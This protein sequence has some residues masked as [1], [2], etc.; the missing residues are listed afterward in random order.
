MRWHV[1]TSLLLILIIA[2]PIPTG[3]GATKPELPSNSPS[4]IISTALASIPSDGSFHPAFFITLMKNGKP[5][6]T[7]EKVNVTL[8]C[9]DE[10]T[11]SVP[12]SVIISEGGYY[13]IVNASSTIQEKKTV[14]VSASASNYLSSKLTA[15]VQPPTGTPTSLKV[16]LLPDILEPKSGTLSEMIVTLVDTYG[17]PAK[18][19][20]DVEVT[21][22]SSNLHFVDVYPKSI[23]IGE[24]SYSAKANIVSQGYVGS[25]TISASTSDFKP[26]SVVAKVSGA[27]PEKLVIWTPSSLGV[28]EET[29]VFI[30]IVD[31]L[32]K[33]AKTPKSLT[34]SLYSTNTTVVSVSASSKILADDWTGTAQITANTPGKATIYAISDELSSIK[35][36]ITVEKAIGNATSL[37]VYPLT[38]YFPADEKTTNVVAV[39]LVDSAGKPVLNRTTTVGVFSTDST[40]LDVMGSIIVGASSSVTFVTGIPTTMG[41]VKITALSGNLQAGE[42]TVN[43]YSPQTTS[44]SVI[45]PPIPSD[46]VVDAC[47]LSTNSG[48]P[49]PMTQDT[50]ILLT[51]GNTQILGVTGSVIL[52]KKNYYTIIQL[53]GVSPGDT[54]ITVQGNGIPTVSSEIKV[55]EVKPTVFSIFYVPALSYIEFPVVI[56]TVTLSGSPVDCDAPI[57]IRITSSNSTSISVPSFVNVPRD[58][59]DILS[60]WKGQKSGQSK[61]TL[62]SGDFT[63]FSLMLKTVPV[64]WSFQLRGSQRGA[65]GATVKITA[66]ASFENKPLQNIII[67]WNGTDLFTNSTITN[68]NGDAFNY[69]TLHNSVNEIYASTSIPG[70]GEVTRTFEIVAVTSVEVY[71]NSSIGVAVEGSGTYFQG[72]SVSLKAPKV[73]EVPGIFSYLDIKY[74]FVTW[75]PLENSHNSTEVI[76]LSNSDGPLYFQAIYE[77]DYTGLYLRVAALSIIVAI[78]FFSVRLI[79]KRRS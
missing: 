79:K 10:R 25:A 31:N 64:D 20:G 49:A 54:K 6:F 42:A 68:E 45:V 37:K 15:I 39:Q 62:S 50:Q 70:I 71:A 40:I 75:Q 16:T 34:I 33:P 19:R 46:G 30:G 48:S 2:I 1:F 3:I 76:K 13:S 27:K 47:I 65:V 7:P 67:R 38:N 5:Y 55:V 21:L 41:S 52:P 4:L 53:D 78:I 35:L 44:M 63:A 59:S 56:Q 61:I 29:K 9:S 66:S 72:D 22:S 11:L 36:T 14:E 73:V 60:F 32:N 8:S 12:P 58:S 23:T 74:N 51:S 43:V 57:G 28:G 69:V 77:A 26:D 18:A 24:G 17:K